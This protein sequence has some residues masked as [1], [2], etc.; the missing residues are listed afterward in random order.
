MKKIALVIMSVLLLFLL[1]A[2]PAKDIDNPDNDEPTQ[3]EVTKMF[4]TIYG[5][6]LEVTLENNSS[7][8]A[9]VE[10][11]KQGD[12]TYTADDYGGFEK[13]GN[14]GHSLPTS[15]SQI[16]T[17]AGDVILYQGNQICIMVGS[18]SWSYTRIGKINGYSAA[19][20]KTLVG[21]GK[22]STQVTLSLN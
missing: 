7:V 3:A 17:S 22:G 11:L 4:I 16:T 1:C 5:N 2:C 10:L 12:I 19:Q 13:V 8:E 9:L 15:N 18:N 20:L 14:I 21:T 6:K